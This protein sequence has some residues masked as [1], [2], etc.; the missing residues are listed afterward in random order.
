MALETGAWVEK[1]LERLAGLWSQRAQ[2]PARSYLAAVPLTEAVQG[3]AERIRSAIEQA[4]KADPEIAT[5]GLALVGDGGAG[6]GGRRAARMR[7][8]VQSAPAHERHLG[9]HDGQ[10]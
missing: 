4:V 8:I 7:R 5:M 9:C 6:R 1:P 10:G 3:G 2:Q